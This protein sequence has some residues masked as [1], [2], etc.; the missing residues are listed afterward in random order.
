MNM[1]NIIFNLEQASFYFSPDDTLLISTDNLFHEVEDVILNAQS[2]Y[3]Q[4]IYSCNFRFV[5]HSVVMRLEDGSLRT[6]Y[7]P[8]YAISWDIRKV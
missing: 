3:K 1:S 7:C 8:L 2:I 4:D 6:D 5:Y